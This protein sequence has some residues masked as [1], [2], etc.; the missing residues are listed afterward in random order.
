MTVPSGNFNRPTDRGG[1]RIWNIRVPRSANDVFKSTNPAVTE[2]ETPRRDFVC[3]GLN[4]VEA[5]GTLLVSIDDDFRGRRQVGQHTVSVRVDPECESRID[6]LRNR[7]QFLERFDY[8]LM[9]LYTCAG[10]VG[11]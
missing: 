5:D 7:Y 3:R 2:L 6:A 9:V 11:R 4:A 10:V 1:V 8:A